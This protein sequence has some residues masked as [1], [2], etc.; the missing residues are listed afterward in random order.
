MLE[1]FGSS[2]ERMK[3]SLS[4]S[5]SSKNFWLASTNFKQGFQGH[6]TVGLVKWRHSECEATARECCSFTQFK[7]R[8]EGS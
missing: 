3:T 5:K 6:L 8:L 2:T 1:F 7:M 4:V